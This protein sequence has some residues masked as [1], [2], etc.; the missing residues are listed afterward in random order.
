M[1][2]KNIYHDQNAAR[3]IVLCMQ[4][5]NFYFLKLGQ[6]LDTINFKTNKEKGMIPAQTKRRRRHRLDLRDM[7]KPQ[8]KS[9]RRERSEANLGVAESY[10]FS[11]RI[12]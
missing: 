3:K 9:K 2:P 11:W 8:K 7:N 12:F 1:T 4:P 10:R 6:D 5:Q